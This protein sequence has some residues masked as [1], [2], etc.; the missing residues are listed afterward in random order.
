[1]GTADAGDALRAIPPFD[2]VTR[3][4]GM[5][6]VHMLFAGQDW[7]G[8]ALLVCPIQLTHSISLITYSLIDTLL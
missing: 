7:C 5:K 2:V 1:M 8:R 4:D 3:G 6:L